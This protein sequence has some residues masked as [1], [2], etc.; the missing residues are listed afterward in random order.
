MQKNLIS[1]SKFCHQNNTSIEFSPSSFFVKDLTM[2]TTF[3]QSQSKDR[4]YEKLVF[5][6]QS[7]LIIAFSSTKSSSNV[8]HHRL[9]HM[10]SSIYKHIVST[11]GLE[12]SKFSNFNFN[13]NSCQYNKSHKLPF[14]TSS[15]VSHSPL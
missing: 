8:W 10:S 14:S 12:L 15:L 3:L 9:G 5:P 4:V 6:S 11:F 1:C 2:G 7:S 13:C